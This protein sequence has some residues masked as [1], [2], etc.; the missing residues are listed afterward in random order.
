MIMG[1]L[2]WLRQAGKRQ[3]PFPAISCAEASAR[4]AAGQITLIDVRTD[5]EWSSS[6]VPPKAHRKT[7]QDADFTDYLHLV[8]KQSEA[9]PIA[10]FC[11]SGARS[12]TAARAAREAGIGEVLIVSGGLEEWRKADLPLD[13]A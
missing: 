6:G 12:A 2:D 9:L 11:L 5:A 8:S 13:K 10:F 7:L 4:S 3:A 1:L